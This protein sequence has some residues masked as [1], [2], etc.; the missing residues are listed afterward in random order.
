MEKYMAYLMKKVK[1]KTVLSFIT[2]TQ[3]N[4][5]NILN[6]SRSTADGSFWQTFSI[7]QL[8]TTFG[9]Y[10]LEFLGHLST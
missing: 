2:A 3:L 7:N 5:W 8:N 6:P 9:T 4:A 10:I 1:P